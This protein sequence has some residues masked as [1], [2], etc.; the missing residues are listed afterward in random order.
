MEPRSLKIF[1]SFFSAASEREFCKAAGLHLRTPH[2]AERRLFQTTWHFSAA[3]STGWAPAVQTV[4]QTRDHRYISE[5]YFPGG[6]RYW[7]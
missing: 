3:G 6:K 7:P 2:V 5:L 4:Q 1:G